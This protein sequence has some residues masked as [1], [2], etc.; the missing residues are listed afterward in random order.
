MEGRLVGWCLCVFTSDVKSLFVGSSRVPLRSIQA[1]VP[2]KTFSDPFISPRKQGAFVFS[3][4]KMQ[5]R[6]LR[7]CRWYS[8][9]VAKSHPPLTLVPIRPAILP[10]NLPP[11]ASRCHNRHSY[12]R[13]HLYHDFFWHYYLFIHLHLHL[14]PRYLLQL[15][16]PLQRYPHPQPPQL[17]ALACATASASLAAT[18]SLAVDA[19]VSFCVCDFCASNCFPSLPFPCAALSR[20]WKG[21]EKMVC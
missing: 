17:Y 5:H 2:K 4:A 3:F 12:R 19:R 6:Y 10:I 13:I 8:F 7:R 16:L 11:P 9:E 1:L 14:L 21:G 15:P 20:S 18:F